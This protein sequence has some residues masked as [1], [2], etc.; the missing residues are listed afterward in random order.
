[1]NPNSMISSYQATRPSTAMEGTSLMV[2]RMADPSS[3]NKKVECPRFSGLVA[4]GTSVSEV[5][6]LRHLTTHQF[7]LLLVTHVTREN[8]TFKSTTSA[9]VNRRKNLN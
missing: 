5:T 8:V 9:K 7:P 2:W 1:M 4:L 3:P 6:V